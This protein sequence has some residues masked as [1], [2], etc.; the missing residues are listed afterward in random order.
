M[1]CTAKIYKF[2]NTLQYKVLKI[3][4]NFQLRYSEGECV[5]LK[6]C[7]EDDHAADADIGI[8]KVW[9]DLTRYLFECPFA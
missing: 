3:Y 8:Y 7:N 2:S 4:K 9:E 1:N 6:C 5:D